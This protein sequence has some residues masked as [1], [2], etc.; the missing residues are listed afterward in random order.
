MTTTPAEG[1][2]A[3]HD[4]VIKRAV[5]VLER[6]E[7]VAACWLEGSLARGTADAW[8]DIDLHVAVSDDSWDSFLNDRRK[9]VQEFGKLLGYDETSLP[10]GAQLVLVTIEGPARVDFYIEMVSRLSGALRLEQPLPLFD[11]GVSESL[12]VTTYVEPLLRAR[13]AELSNQLFFGGMWPARLS[14]RKEWGTLFA[15]S[16][17]VVN[18]FLIPAILIQDSPEH[19]FRPMFHNERY[20][21]GE[22]R[23]RVNELV[24]KLGA[25]FAGI[26]DSG[27]DPAAVASAYEV[28]LTE[29]WRELRA[30]S[31]KFQ[32]EYP[33]ETEDAMRA[34]LRNQLRIFVE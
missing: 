1:P 2:T 31:A 9:V 32:V 17:Y 8:S 27:P 18:Q 22:R 26:E 13:V 21:G 12:R 3:I 11:K 16:L 28:L 5:E 24:G 34:Y 30:A 29:V 19:F 15:N 33:A 14:G 23:R 25:S 4:G 10:W 20:L 7:R 6:D